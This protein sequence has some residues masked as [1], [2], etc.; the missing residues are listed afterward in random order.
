MQQILYEDAQISNICI[1]SQFLSGIYK[2][3]KV[4]YFA[5]DNA[6]KIL[7]ENVNV[8]SFQVRSRV[9]S[10]V[11]LIQTAKNFPIFNKLRSDC[12][13]CKKWH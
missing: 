4:I 7:N 5:S 8:N 9:A 1:S 10:I 3:I 12:L 11:F 6:S 2:I 13:F